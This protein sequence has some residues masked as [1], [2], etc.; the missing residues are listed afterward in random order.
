M[1]LAVVMWFTYQPSRDHE[2][3]LDDARLNSMVLLRT[4]IGASATSE[5]GC[6]AIGVS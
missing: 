5:E 1:D 3:K 2:G 4:K 6:E